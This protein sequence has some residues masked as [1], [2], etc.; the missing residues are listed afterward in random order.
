MKIS[1]VRDHIS[2]SSISKYMK[3]SMRWYYD[4]VIAPEKKVESLPLKIGS[5]YHNAI[6]KLYIDRDYDGGLLLLE[7]F[8]KENGRYAQ[9]DIGA[10]INCYK[11]YYL[12]VYPLYQSRVEKVEVKGYVDIPGIEVPLEY[13]MDLL[14]TDGVI[15]DHKTIGRVVPGIEY[16]LQFDLYSYAYYKEYGRLPSK[17][18]YHDAYKGTG[19]VAVRSKIP[20]I[21]DMMKA[22]SC[23]VG[24]VKAIEADI[25]IPCYDKHCSYC[26]HKDMC[27]REH[28]SI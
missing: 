17:V 1:E 15:A 4:Y 14:T 20:S 6:E 21:S 12:K 25:F 18:E 28:G 9:K 23:A 5:A 7:E 27:D 8:A 16:S 13:R 3:C 10:I 24:V 22:V 19:S 26:P 11:D 2:Y